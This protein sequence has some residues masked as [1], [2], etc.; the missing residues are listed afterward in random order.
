M[1][2]SLYSP[3]SIMF[4]VLPSNPQSNQGS[5]L[6]RLRYRWQTEITLLLLFHHQSWTDGWK[7]N[8]LTNGM[9]ELMHFINKPLA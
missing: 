1:A 4:P 8:A 5:V 3:P 7:F 6:D 9:I 2:A